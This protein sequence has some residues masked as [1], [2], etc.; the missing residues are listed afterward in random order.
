VFC[1][2]LASTAIA[3]PEP[4]GI[5]AENFREKQAIRELITMTL[6]LNQSRSVIQ[7]QNGL[8]E[9]RTGSMAG[10]VG[11]MG[12]HI[13]NQMFRPGRFEHKQERQ[14]NYA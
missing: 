4:N 1:H 8:A 9:D 7:K 2:D 14:C 3:P 10:S 6:R 12:R 5:Q 13:E 11:V